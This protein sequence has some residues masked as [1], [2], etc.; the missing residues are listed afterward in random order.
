MS[1]GG[2][3]YQIGLSLLNEASATDISRCNSSFRKCE[4]CNNQSTPIGVYNGRYLLVRCENK[5][6]VR[7]WGICL[8]C[9]RQRSYLST[10]QKIQRHEQNMHKN[11]RQRLLTELQGPRAEPTADD[12]FDSR[13]E[14]VETAH[15]TE[16]SVPE[17]FDYMHCDYSQ[18]AFNDDDQSELEHTLVEV[19]DPSSL[20]FNDDASKSYFE[21]YHMSVSSSGGIDYLVKKSFVAQNLRAD[22]YGSIQLPEQHAELQIRI[23]HLCFLLTK[24]QCEL[25]AA[26]MQGCYKVG[27]EDGY[28]SAQMDIGK[29]ITTYSSTM[30]SSF[31]PVQTLSTWTARQLKGNEIIRQAHRWS[32]RIPRS[33]R[34][35]R[36]LHVEGANAIIPNLPLPIVQKDIPMHSYVLITD[37]IRHFLGHNDLSDIATISP[38]IEPLEISKVEHSSTSQRAQNILKQSLRQCPDQQVWKSYVILWSDDVEPNRT[39][40][41]RGSIWLLT[42]T[43]ATRDYNG[44]SMLHTYPI[45]VAKKNHDHEPVIEKIEKDMEKLRSGNLE[46]YIGKRRK[47]AR[48]QFEMFA[49]IQD[50]PERRDFN[51]LRA[52]NGTHSARFGV[53]ANHG[54]L[55]STGVLQACPACVRT[56]LDRVREAQTMLPLPTCNNCLN[57]DVLSDPNALGLYPPP[58]NYPLWGVDDDWYRSS[59]RCRLVETTDGI[60]IRPFKITYETLK[61]AVDFVHDAYCNH[62]WSHVQCVSFLQVEGLD[63]KFIEELLN[64]SSYSMS[65]KVARDDPGKYQTIIDDANKN[66]GKYLKISYPAPWM[67]PT[68]GLELHPDVIMHLLFLGVVKTVVQQIQAWLSAQMK[69]TSFIRSTEGYLEPFLA[70]TIDWLNIMPYQGG[71]LG[72]WVSENFLGFSRLMPWFYQNIQGATRSQPDHEPPPNVPQKQWTFKQNKYWLQRRNLDTTGRKAEVAKRVADYL[73]QENPPEAPP[74]LELLPI[75]V[76]DTILSLTEVLRCTMKASVT[77]AL[78]NQTRYAIRLFLSHYDTMCKPLQASDGQS[79]KAKKPPVLSSYNFICMLNLPNA[80]ELFGPLRCLWEGGP[81]GEGFARFAKPYMTQGVHQQNWHNNLLIRLLRARTFEN[82]LQNAAV[83]KSDVTST[84]ALRDRKG[85]YHKYDSEFTFKRLFDRNRIKEYRPVSVIIVEQNSNELHLYGVVSDYESI[86]EVTMSDDQPIQKFGMDYYKFSVHAEHSQQWNLVRSTVTRIGFGILL[87]LLE[88]GQS[89][90]FALSSSNWEVLSTSTS[91]PS[92]L[93]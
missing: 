26:V 40:S 11:K 80:M 3:S 7:E 74:D 82:L 20:G 64:H 51:C 24:G 8:D 72:G 77:P 76:V 56:M 36:T 22:D 63:D 43:I 54:T 41:N 70:M 81:R 23:A 21:Q 88:E 45:A 19:K 75:H 1:S 55:Y 32:T 35:I 10:K 49:A 31:I 27:S 9:S 60:R 29:S 33:W 44:H 46:F 85:S 14:A 13:A 38:N 52:G 59:P 34:E 84:E 18:D 2:L 87:P 57:W 78:V 69:L 89:G 93:D 25:L 53:S 66:P 5:S 68:I 58:K 39:K 48:I 6:C 92:L 15:E 12:A 65:L 47:M 30:K 28:A 71:K 42:A 67:R 50:Q 86:M 16:N 90:V 37:C 61:A 62:G 17:S 91:L 4:L 79:T 73:A 83:S